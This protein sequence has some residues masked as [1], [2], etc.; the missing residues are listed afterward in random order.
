MQLALWW[1]LFENASASLRSGDIF[2]AFIYLYTNSNS[3]V[4]YIQGING[5]LQ[6][7]DPFARCVSC[8][9]H[10]SCQRLHVIKHF[11]RLIVLD[12]LLAS[13]DLKNSTLQS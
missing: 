12:C 13:L 1:T 10:P 4:G 5:I 9:F 7:K 2:S 6:V 8:Q 3:T 11:W